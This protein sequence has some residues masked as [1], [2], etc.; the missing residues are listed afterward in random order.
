MMAV[1]EDEL[2]Y[3]NYFRVCEH[4][5][6]L[7]DVPLS[8]SPNFPISFKLFSP[9]EMGDTLTPI[10]VDRDNIGVFCVSTY[11][12]L[13]GKAHRSGHPI[14]DIFGMLVQED[15]SL[16]ASLADGC[17]WG[18][19]ARDAA[20]A[21][22]HGFLEYILARKPFWIGSTALHLGHLL[23]RGFSTAHDN[24]LDGVEQTLSEAGTTTLLGVLVSPMLGSPDWMAITCSVGDTKAFLY[25]PTADTVFEI[26]GP[27]AR[28][29]ATDPGG[30][31]GP[32]VE[33]HGDP[34]LRNLFLQSTKV[35]AGDY[36][37]ML[38]DGV[39]DNIDPLYQ[40]IPPRD[41]GLDADQ[42]DED[43][44]LHLEVRSTWIRRCIRDRFI[45]RDGAPQSP[46]VICEVLQKFVLDLTESSREFHRTQP[47]KKL[48]R[49]FK[50]YPGKMDHSTCICIRIPS[51]SASKSS[52]PP[53][54][55]NQSLPVLLSL[56]SSADSDNSMSDSS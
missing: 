47:N 28:G 4:Y 5:H 18:V 14:A 42:W 6:E 11:P 16:I 43:D 2:G 44:A 56:S 17:N 22:S 30:R 10:P 50:L 53:S 20:W 33:P 24:I 9:A 49:D 55:P 34:D 45:L 41:C 36:L 39:Y 7:P 25:S 35:S 52:A 54:H 51:H 40:G 12:I 8:F 21:A 37:L 19:K 27:Q 31:L 15:G 48:P 23:L 13:P 29:N 46:A 38:T 32:H 26:S 3:A 1:E